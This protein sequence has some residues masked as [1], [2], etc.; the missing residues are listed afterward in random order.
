MSDMASSSLADYEEMV[1]LVKDIDGNPL[2]ISS[3]K[4]MLASKQLLGGGVPMLNFSG[5]PLGGAGTGAPG[6]LSLGPT[7]GLDLSKIG[8]DGAPKGIG[9]LAIPEKC[10][11]DFQ[12]EFMQHFDEFS[13]SWRMLI[14][15]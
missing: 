8:K 4:L 9:K 3:K 2:E 6:G 1:R 14:L 12:D 13:E 7:I 5:G 15:K 10:E 11:G